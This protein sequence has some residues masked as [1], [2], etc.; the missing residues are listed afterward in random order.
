MPIRDSVPLGAPCWIDLTSSD[1]GR[2]QEFYGAVFG[3]TFEDKGP[4]LDRRNHFTAPPP[5]WQ[6][7]SSQSNRVRGE[8]MHESNMEG[9]R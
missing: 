3:W 7:T 1:L 5:V 2:A 6:Q 8:N 9:H 4:A